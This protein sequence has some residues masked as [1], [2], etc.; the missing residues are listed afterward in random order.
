MRECVSEIPQGPSRKGEGTHARNER[1]AY[2]SQ[3]IT[4]SSVATTNCSPTHPRAYVMSGK[5]AVW[6]LLETAAVCSGKNFSGR[7]FFGGVLS[8]EKLTVAEFL[9]AAG[10]QQRPAAV[11]LKTAA[12]SSGT[13]EDCSGQ[14]RYCRRPQRST[15]VLPQT[16]AVTSATGEDP[17]DQHQ[18]PICI[19]E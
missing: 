19:A 11:L 15:V 5:C 13:A 3:K 6:L 7:P 14:R 8:A 18:P 2:T 12:V 16:A 1:T 10:G 4:L 17:A 9:V